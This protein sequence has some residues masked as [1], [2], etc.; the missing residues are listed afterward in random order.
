M[1]NIS[2]A[3][4]SDL[5]ALAELLEDMDRFYGVTECP[6]LDE[7][8]AEIGALLFSDRPAPY[9]LLARDGAQ[10]VGLASYS[11]L[12]PA[13]GL[14]QSLFLKELYVREAHRGHGVGRLL[15]QRVFE[16]AA[17][18]DCSRVEWMTEQTNADAQAFYARLG[19]EANTEKVFYR[20]EGIQAAR[21][22]V[23]RW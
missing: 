17:E 21:N 22:T 13:A 16:I 6:P 5:G 4:A 11:F 18:T 7:R 8:V 15:M 3:Q 12:W 20:V 14:T 19:H 9:V 1:V 2:S 23:R 10:A